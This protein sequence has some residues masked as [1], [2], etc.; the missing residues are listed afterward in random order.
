M[1]SDNREFREWESFAKKLATKY[2]TA[3]IELE[4]LEQEALLTLLEELPKYDPAIGVSLR[5]FLGRGIRNKL[6]SLYRKT[7]N[8]VQIEQFWLV[9]HV[10]G[11]RDMHVKAKSKSEA[12][13]V[14]A[15]RPSEYVNVQ[16][17]KTLALLGPS[18]DED[19]G[20]N[21]EGN[22]DCMTLHE[23]L[24][25]KPLQE[26]KLI[27]NEGEKKVRKANRNGDE[28]AEIFRLRSEGRTFQ[29]IAATLGK[30]ENTL[31]YAYIRA[32]KR[33]KS[34]KSAA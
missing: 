22:T 1:S 15:A 9:E 12:E 29:E 4:D 21:N 18:L 34:K 33:I 6:A 10:S 2:V 3:G 23:V 26:L 5:V 32:Q 16:N 24:G 13:A 27:A 17:V 11:S 14:V 25:E 28:L 31:Y 8:L 20:G 7:L 19:A 30:N